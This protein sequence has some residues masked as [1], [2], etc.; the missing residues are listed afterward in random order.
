METR[1]IIFDGQ[2]AD[3][4]AQLIKDQIGSSPQ[5][6]DRAAGLILEFDPERANK[7]ADLIEDSPPILVTEDKKDA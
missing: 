6:A 3:R 5:H 4:A 1:K 7:A 2:F